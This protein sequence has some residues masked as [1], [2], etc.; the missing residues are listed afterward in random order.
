MDAA[1]FRLFLQPLVENSLLHGIRG[2]KEKGYV[3]VSIQKRG[4][5]LRC[6]VMDTGAGMTGEEKAGLESRFSSDDAGGIGL[7]NLYRRLV[8]RY[9][10]DSALRV[11]SK[12]GMGT[13]VSFYIPCEKMKV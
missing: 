9:G 5:R 2:S 8:L 10:E 1:V 13:A 12:K 11:W 6:C 7:A 3:K 4:E